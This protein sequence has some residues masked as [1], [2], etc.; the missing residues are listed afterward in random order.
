[1]IPLTDLIRLAE[2]AMIWLKF[3]NHF[4]L[5]SSDSSLGNVYVNTNKSVSNW[6]VVCYFIAF[7]LPA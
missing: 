4:S 1:M 6:F 2:F 5:S 3:Y 7:E